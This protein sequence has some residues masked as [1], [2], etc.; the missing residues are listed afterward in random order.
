MT[1]ITTTEEGV[2]SFIHIGTIG[3]L[4]VGQ[5]FATVVSFFSYKEHFRP[6]ISYKQIP[7]F[8]TI[9]SAFLTHTPFSLLLHI[10]RISSSSLKLVVKFRFVHACIAAEQKKKKFQT[11]KRRNL[12]NR[13]KLICKTYNKKQEDQC[14]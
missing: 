10:L 13:G 6:N 12:N 5:S 11:T 8:P 4:Q 9:F 14:A 7:H 2:I 1:T 3:L